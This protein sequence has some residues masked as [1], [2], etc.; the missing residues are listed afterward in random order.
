L[1]YLHIDNLYRARDILLFRA[2][3]ALEK[4]HGT[5]AHLLWTGGRVQ[6][7]SGGSKQASFLALFDDAALS[8][9]FKE[10]FDE[11]KVFVYG[12]AYGGKIMGMSATYGTELQFVVFE[13]KV[14]DSWLAVPQAEEV[15]QKLGLEFVWYRKI[16]C[17]LD[18]IDAER[19]APSIQAK[20]CKCGEHKREGIVLRPLIELKKNNGERIIAKHKHDDFKE[21]STSRPL[22]EE[23]MKV[24]CDAEAVATEWVTPMRVQHVLDAEEFKMEFGEIPRFIKAMVADVYR[25]A[26]G[27]IVESDAVRK[28]IAR[29]AAV[30]FKKHIQVTA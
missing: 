29:H 21:T 25:E 10:L 1:S 24:L 27:E 14:G 6:Y 16:L 5:S 12:E 22:N 2:C 30:L 13:V 11:Q 26:M 20:R 7:S 4:I 17:E 19:D 28:A 8:K 23:Q 15:A 18:V 9:I 3:Y